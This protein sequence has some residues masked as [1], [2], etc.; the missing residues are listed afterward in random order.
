MLRV[1]VLDEPR[2]LSQK[3]GVRAFELED[4]PLVRDF[5]LLGRPWTR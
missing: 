3:A 2:T 5:E 4:D 1:Q